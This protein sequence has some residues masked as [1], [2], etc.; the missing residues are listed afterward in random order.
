MSE[1]T[2]RVLYSFPHA[3]D[4]S[5]I[6]STALQQL[7]GL[8][9]LGV[10]LCVFCTS[11]GDVELPPRIT[12][13]QTLVVAGT[14]VPHR[15]LGV[16][17]AYTYHDHAVARW[18][19][20]H[21]DAV[22]L[23]HAW[24]R[25]CLATLRAARSLGMPALRE[26]PSPH[27]ASAIRNAAE[28]SEQVGVPLPATHSHAFNSDVLARELEEYAAATA[29]LVPSS[30]AFDQFV[31]EGFP[32]S[33]L[34]QHRYGCDLDRFAARSQPRPH[35][36]PFTAVFV[37][38]GDPA[39]GL[40]VAL[41][42]WESASLPNAEF[43]IAGKVLPD[44][45]AVLG[46]RLRAPGVRTLG[47]VRDV[48]ALLTQADVLLLPSWTE[49]SALVVMEAQA[50]GC[51]PLVSTSSGADGTPGVDFLEHPVGSAE[52]LARQLRQLAENPV[53]LSAMSDRGTQR[54]AVLSWDHA[55]Q[56]LLECYRQA[57]ATARV[58]QPSAS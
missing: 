32:Q 16:Q 12:V 57:A 4:R 39:K 56:V 44:Y 26:S 40:H 3:L 9:R 28:A 53:L 38:R 14:R 46:D 55:A 50:S 23:V 21:A 27:T 35:D 31:L 15:A 2:P 47:F 18:L 11:V 17:R 22:D 7:L 52:V 10:P 41:E 1:S 42:A 29:V 20:H 51:V 6:S 24:P 58:P 49:G 25:G 30:F 34:L 5:G 48:P 19:R 45:A 13:H 8:D 43:L 54:R 36:R 37:G 33:A